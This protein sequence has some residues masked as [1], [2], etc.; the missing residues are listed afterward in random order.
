MSSTYRRSAC[1]IAAGAVLSG[2][3]AGSAA[4]AA[5]PAPDISFAAYATGD[6]QGAAHA[7]AEAAALAEEANFAA[8][9]GATCGEPLA[10][11][12]YQA[13]VP[14]GSAAAVV[15][16]VSCTAPTSATAFLGFSGFATSA[17]E[18]SAMDAATQAADTNE[19]AY[20]AA[21]GWT[22]TEGLGADSARPIQL[23]QG[24]WAAVGTDAP[25][26]CQSAG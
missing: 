4:A 10:Q 6:S 17:D 9:S 19:T 23:A 24:G 7:A 5:D 11:T 13:V 3:F 12:T 25:D 22:C 1:A 14:S 16:E 8:Q 20:F 26:F 2:A 18:F 21:V 15:I